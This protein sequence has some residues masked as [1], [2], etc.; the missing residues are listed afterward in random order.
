MQALVQSGTGDTRA[1]YT[2]LAAVVANSQSLLDEIAAR[3][4][5]TLSAAASQTI[6]GAID[7]IDGSSTAGQNNRIYSGIL[8]TMASPDFIAQK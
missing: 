3:L 2:S 4:G 6:R 1:D 7:S 5:V 8:L